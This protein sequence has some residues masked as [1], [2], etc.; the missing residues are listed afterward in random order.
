MRTYARVA[1][2]QS[3]I[4]TV[5][6]LLLLILVLGGSYGLYASPLFRVSAV[7]C[8]VEGGDPCPEGVRE[9]VSQ[10][11]GES[12]LTVN[13]SPSEEKIANAVK[14]IE[15]INVFR[16][17]PRTLQ[18][19]IKL[20]E[21]AFYA[22]N[23]GVSTVFR[24]DDE[25]DVYGAAAD[26]ARYIVVLFA[27]DYPLAV[28]STVAPDTAGLFALLTRKLQTFPQLVT[29]IRYAT[30]NEILISFEDG[31]KAVMKSEG[32]EKQLDTLQRILNDATMETQVGIIDV[33]FEHP[34]IK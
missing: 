25:G 29:S 17:Y 33:R 15:T 28:G 11:L 4:R 5:R 34:V 27:P 9:E 30:E 26:N 31:T 7:E 19:E 12:M 14:R 22:Q 2:R 18:I 23:E 32:A 20:R 16:R 6:M 1:R 13:V 8:V 10:K 24:V 3:V 21:P